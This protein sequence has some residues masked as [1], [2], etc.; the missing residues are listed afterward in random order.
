MYMH[1]TVEVI[2][3]FENTIK[4]GNIYLTAAAGDLEVIACNKIFEKLL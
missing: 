1:I 4:S 3:S 2:Q